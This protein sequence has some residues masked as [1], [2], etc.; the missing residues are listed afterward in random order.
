MGVIIPLNAEQDMGHAFVDGK[1]WTPL[2]WSSEEFSVY[3]LASGTTTRFNPAERSEELFK[4]NFDEGGYYGGWTLSPDGSI[5]YLIN[6]RSES[7]TIVGISTV[8]GKDVSL[9]KGVID[10]QQEDRDRLDNCGVFWTA[11]GLTVCLVNGGDGYDKQLHLL[12][13]DVLNLK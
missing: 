7:L 4:A 13:F 9:F 1:V 12:T 3:D 10:L 6:K 11:D 8:T 2:D 5:L